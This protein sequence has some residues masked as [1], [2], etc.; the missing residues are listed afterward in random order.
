MLQI[1]NRYTLRDAEL[2]QN[3]LNRFYDC[4]AVNITNYILMLKFLFLIT[5][6]LKQKKTIQASTI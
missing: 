6:F 3:D 4:I 2:L 5:I 1:V